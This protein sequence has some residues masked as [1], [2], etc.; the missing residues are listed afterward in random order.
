MH[1][2]TGMPAPSFA[3]GA[4]GLGARCRPVPIC[5]PPS[6]GAVS[7][8]AEALDDSCR[9]PAE[10]R[11]VRRSRWCG[12]EPAPIDDQ[13]LP[14]TSSVYAPM[15]RCARDQKVVG[16]VLPGYHSSARTLVQR[17][18]YCFDGASRRYTFPKGRA[19]PAAASGRTVLQG[20]SILDAWR[21]YWL[22]KMSP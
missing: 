22:S 2:C 16:P 8:A 5:T 14:S 11:P 10:R 6:T 17:W 21:G 3:L 19:E 12:G 9:V 4:H 1:R 7:S 20:G 13:Q 18:R 15:H